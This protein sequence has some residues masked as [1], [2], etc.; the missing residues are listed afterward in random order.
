MQLTGLHH[1]TAVTAKAPDNLAFY[2]QTLGLH[3]VKKT[4]NQDDVSAYH[5]FYGDETGSAG[6][7]LT[8]FDWAHIGANRPGIGTISTIGLR[9]RGPE[10]LEW[11][12]RRLADAGVSHGG[13]T[14]RGGRSLLE[15][16]DPEGQRLR[17]ADDTGA[18][19][20]GTPWGGSPVPAAQFVR[21]LDSVTLTVRR[22]GPTAEVLTGV[23]GMRAARQYERDGRTVSVFETGPGGAGAEIEV[24]ERPDLTFGQVGAGGV[25]HVALRTPNIA[26]QIA[27]QKRI[28]EAG[29]GTSGLV[30]R[31][32][33][34]SLYF[35]EPN[36][37]LFEIATDGPG[38]AT[39]EDAAHLGERLSLP[40]FLEP[41]RQR[42]EAGLKPLTV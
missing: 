32:Y 16:T 18:P 20:G 30:D 29:L 10:A 28:E 14:E 12:A 41:H 17:L 22:L 39:D 23:L 38:F 34:N 36:G 21:G 8:F 11:W 6:T 40:P 2:T 42:I 37:I 3:L 7:E 24:E 4:V 35:R 1:V 15:F 33:F 25:H 5:L 27:W 13:I 26:E 31:F 9:V 19:G